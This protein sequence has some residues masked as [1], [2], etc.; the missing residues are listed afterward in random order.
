MK[1]LIISL[2]ILS[3]FSSCKKEELIIETPATEKESVTVIIKNKP[4][5]SKHSLQNSSS[6]GG[7]FWSVFEGFEADESIVPISFTSAS[8]LPLSN[9]NGKPQQL[10]NHIRGL[11]QLNGS[12]PA[13]RANLQETNNIDNVINRHK[14]ADVVVSGNYK[15]DKQGDYLSIKAT[16]KFFEN[17][18]GDYFVIP[19]V[20]VNNYGEFQAGMTGNTTQH[21]NVPVAIA[22]PK[23]LETTIWDGYPVA[24]GN[25]KE[26]FF[27][28]YELE[29]HL[30]TKWAASSLSMAF[31]I[32][33]RR[34]DGSLAFVNAFN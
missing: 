7:N 6:C 25:T 27:K 23:D 16:V 22:K 31:I 32:Y 1:T 20:L 2:I 3:A 10:T 4:L 28:N 29:C 24:S 30:D 5:V 34:N 19:Y 8:G 12:F 17:T 18:S 9:F 11:F 14:Q 15:M 33:K 21:F 13:L 26:R